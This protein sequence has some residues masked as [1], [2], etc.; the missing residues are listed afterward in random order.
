MTTLHERV[1]T[2]GMFE[3]VDQ[4]HA[5]PV[6]AVPSAKPAGLAKGWLPASYA[7]QLTR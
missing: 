1:E 6:P 5:G 4:H 7:A 3:T 2:G